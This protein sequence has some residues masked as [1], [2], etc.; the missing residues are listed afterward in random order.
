MKKKIGKKV[1]V[2]VITGPFLTENRAYKLILFKTVPTNRLFMHKKIKTEI[3]VT[4]EWVFIQ[5]RG[6]GQFKGT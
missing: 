6:V 1:F 3:Q 2:C 5:I 4:F